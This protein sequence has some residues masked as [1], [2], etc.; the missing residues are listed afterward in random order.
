MSHFVVIVAVPPEKVAEANGDLSA[1]IAPMLAPYHEFECTGIDN[2]YVVDV[3]ETDGARASWEYATTRSGE[4]TSFADWARS[5]YGLE[6]VME[7]ETPD[8]SGKHKY[9]YIEVRPAKAKLQI[10]LAADD[11]KVVGCEHEVIRV[12]NRT[13]PNR[14]WDWYVIGGRW[15]GMFSEEGTE[16][17]PNVPAALQG[18]RRDG[19]S[20][21]LG[22]WPFKQRIETATERY[23]RYYDDIHA[24]MAQH[25]KPETWETIKE[26]Y[27]SD[28][29]TARKVFNQ[30]PAIVAAREVVAFDATDKNRKHWAGGK[31]IDFFDS[32]TDWIGPRDDVV[33][34][35]A[36]TTV[37]PFA[38]V[39]KDGWHEKG[40]M[41]MFAVV[42]GENKHWHREIMARL[43]AM[44]PDTIL[45]AVDCHV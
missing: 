25:P 30:Q 12:V 29:D 15:S 13:N 34:R 8:I 7:G 24:A 1:A 10:K 37:L 11:G 41:L 20:I 43:E 26:R 18:F 21:R 38:L 42:A 2:E 4:V 44:D 36:A 5:H 6:F 23:G 32:V 16:D 9:G 27:A 40:Q 17:N 39:D 35:K 19:N 45:V 28:Y 22:D 31:I 3:D 14:K 33:F